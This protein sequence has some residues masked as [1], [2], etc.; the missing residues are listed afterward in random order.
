MNGNLVPADVQFARLLTG[1]AI[2]TFSAVTG[3]LV[4]K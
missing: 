4:A 1:V 3:E 2:E